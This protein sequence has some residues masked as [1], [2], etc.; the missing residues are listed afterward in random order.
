MPIKRRTT[1]FIYPTIKEQ[2][3]DIHNLLNNED[4]D[5]EDGDVFGRI[6]ETSNYLN[7]KASFS[8][9][10][11]KQEKFQIDVNELESTYNELFKMIGLLTIQYSPM[12]HGTPI[13]KTIFNE[14]YNLKT[15]GLRIN[16][17]PQNVNSFKQ[18]ESVSDLTMNLLYKLMDIEQTPQLGMFFHNQWFRSQLFEQDVDLS[19]LIKLWRSLIP[20]VSFPLTKSDLKTI[21]SFELI[22][23]NDKIDFITYHETITNSNKISKNGDIFQEIGVFKI[24]SLI[25]DDYDSCISGIRTSIPSKDE[26][27]TFIP[28]LLYLNSNHQSLNGFTSNHELI[29][30]YGLHPTY[31]VSINNDTAYDYDFKP[32]DECKLLFNLDLPSN[33]ILDKYQ[34]SNLVE[35]KSFNISNEMDLELPVYKINNSGSSILIHLNDSIIDE[36][37]EFTIPLHLRY[38]TPMFENDSFTSIIPTGNLYWSCPIT[39]EEQNLI[40]N[41][42]FY[43]RR[44]SIDSFEDNVKLYHIPNI[45][46]NYLS[47]V[48]PTGNLSQGELIEF[49]TV[50]C[51]ISSLVYLIK[52]LLL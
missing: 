2:S 46:D 4:E 34:I 30:P 16:I 40:S 45:G 15:Q 42:I 12:S 39:S 9:P 47:I 33:I 37:K 38:A 50:I 31:K 36:F 11:S 51:L 26:N 20:N 6:E 43:E 7:I 23:N 29:E 21:T 19:I 28:T 35:F 44:L 14:Y 41:S 10:L 8:K 32:M 48:Q 5:G 22:L 24:E 52:K 25:I 13:T 17:A 3:N 1:Y 49:V 27:L 18:Y